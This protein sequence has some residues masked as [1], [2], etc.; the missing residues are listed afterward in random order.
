MDP[1]S[2]P[3]SLL[4][5]DPA[6]P[7]D[8][9]SA[10]PRRRGRSPAR[11]SGGRRRESLSPPSSSGPPP[12]LPGLHLSPPPLPRPPRLVGARLTHAPRFL[13]RH[14]FSP[15]APVPASALPCEPLSEPYFLRA[16]A[17]TSARRPSSP[18]LPGLK[19]PGP[20]APPSPHSFLFHLSLPPCPP[21]LK[22]GLLPSQGLCQLSRF[23]RPHS[24]LSFPQ[25]AVAAGSGSWERRR[26]RRGPGKAPGR[27][28]EGGCERR[29]GRGKRRGDEERA[30]PTTGARGAAPESSPALDRPQRRGAGGGGELSSGLAESETLVLTCV[31]RGPA[32]NSTGS[33]GAGEQTRA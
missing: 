10:P 25:A 8:K 26:R 5:S 6:Q 30:P 32:V 14:S 19:A 3:A 23:P 31:R 12:T 33:W 9:E 15:P 13:P 16:L 2:D 11:G 24:R 27:R 21:P 20:A 4:A 1:A 29:L 7:E 18:A 28:E 22:S 17:L